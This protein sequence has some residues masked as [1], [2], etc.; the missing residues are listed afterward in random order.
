MG[1]PRRGQGSA[2]LLRL[3]LSGLGLTVGTQGWRQA[4][5]R[6]ASEALGWRSRVV[7]RGGGHEGPRWGA[8]WGGSGGQEGWKGRVKLLKCLCGTWQ[9]LG[10]LG[11][12]PPWAEAPDLLCFSLRVGREPRAP[13]HAPVFYLC[14]PGSG[15]LRAAG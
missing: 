6:E 14:C 1:E 7:L 15:A 2:R 10:T 12:E 11:T 4:L 13:F 3:L 8:G 5:R 9:P